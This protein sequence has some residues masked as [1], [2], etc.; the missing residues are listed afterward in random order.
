MFCQKETL[1]LTEIDNLTEHYTGHFPFNAI[2]IK[3]Q[4]TIILPN[5]LYKPKELN[6]LQAHF[7]SQQSGWITN[8]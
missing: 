8:Y 5:I 4:P 6:G 7:F 1:P 3:L 2:G